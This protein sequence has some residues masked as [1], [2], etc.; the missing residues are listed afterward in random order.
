MIKTTVTGADDAIAQ[1]TREL[2]K[3]KVDK[4]VTVGI[5]EDAGN[6]DSDDITNASLGAI[7]EFGAEVNHPGGTSYGYASKAAANRNEVRFLKSGS[8]Y[9]ELGVTGPHTVSIPARPWLNPGVASGDE[10]YLKIIE[11]VIASGEPLDKAL[12]QIG[13]VAV[14]MVQKY[15]TDL[16]TPPNAPSTIKAKG[17]S[18]PLIDSGALRQSVTYKVTSTKPTE[19]L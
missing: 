18:N 15:M 7:H 9:M 8:G 11:R 2:E 1:I 19:G 16:K 5:H 4:F 17:S 14:G 10:E 12:E 6:H 13:V 3:L